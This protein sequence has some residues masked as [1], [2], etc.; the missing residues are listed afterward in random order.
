MPNTALGEGFLRPSAELLG[1]RRTG[2]LG[3][4]PLGCVRDAL[5]AEVFW[6]NLAGSTRE[7]DRTA[8]GLTESA[9]RTLRSYC[10]K[11]AITE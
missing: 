2:A 10:N 5:V 1:E 8:G 6:G 4:E 7:V 9:L 11:N 3:R